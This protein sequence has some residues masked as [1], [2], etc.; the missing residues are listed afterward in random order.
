MPAA[1]TT[2]ELQASWRSVRAV[3][4]MIQTNTG[5]TFY[6]LVPHATGFAQVAESLLL[7]FATSVLEAS[8]LNLR[9]AG[10]FISKRSELGSLMKASK[11]ALPWQDYATIDQV[12]LRRNGV[13]HRAELLD[14]GECANA[15]GAIARELIAWSILEDDSRATHTV[16]FKPDA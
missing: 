2:D 4:A 8:L 10:R 6:S 13:A 1:L 5:P 11:E 3:E 15:L 12:R 7:V 9:D 16:S 14:R